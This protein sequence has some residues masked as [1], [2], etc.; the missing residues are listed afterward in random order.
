MEPSRKQDRQC[1]GPLRRG[2]VVSS[3]CEQRAGRDRDL[4][5]TEVGGWFGTPRNAEAERGLQRRG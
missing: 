3:S 2:S 4:G 1:R 5:N